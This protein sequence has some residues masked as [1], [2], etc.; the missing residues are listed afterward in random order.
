[1]ATGANITLSGGTTMRQVIGSSDLVEALDFNKPNQ[2]NDALLG[3]AQDVTL[4]TFVEANTFGWSQGGTGVGNAS[5]AATIL[6]SG[7]NGAFKDLQDDVQSQ[8]AFLGVGLRTGVETDVTDVTTIT[9]TTWNNLMLNIEDCWNTRFVPASTTITTDAT[10]TWTPS[11]TNTLTQITTWTFS[12]EADCRGFFNGGGKLGITASATD[13]TGTQNDTWETR[14]ANLGEVA[15]GYLTTTAG[16]GTLSGVGFYELTTTNQQ[17]VQY[18]GAA[19]PYTGDY[20]RVLAKVNSI[21]NPTI[22]TFQTELVDA[23]DNNVDDPVTVDISINSRR[24]QPDASGSGFSFDI[25]VDSTG[26]ISGS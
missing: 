10:V 15:L 18:F 8:C 25:P 19:S 14:L 23:G 21:T 12:T 24:T 7:V 11:W 5:V 9:A 22:V 13:G 6:A 26:A 2:N 4:G 20:I 1:M 16:A 17:L 3:D